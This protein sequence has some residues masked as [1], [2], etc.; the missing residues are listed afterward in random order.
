MNSA[1]ARPVSGQPCCGTIM[2][3]GNCRTIGAH[4]RRILLLTM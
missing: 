3:M 1:T 2:R 4:R